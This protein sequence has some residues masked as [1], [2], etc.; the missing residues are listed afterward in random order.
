MYHIEVKVLDLFDPADLH[1]FEMSVCL[2]P[3]DCLAD[4]LQVKV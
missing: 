4:Y 2:E 3:R 1:L